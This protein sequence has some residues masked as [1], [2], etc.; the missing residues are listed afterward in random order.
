M[1]VGSILGKLAGPSGFQVRQ[2]AQQEDFCEVPIFIPILGNTNT[3][4]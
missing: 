1:D 2:A 3:L 4:C